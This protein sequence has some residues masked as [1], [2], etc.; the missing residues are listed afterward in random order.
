MFLMLSETAQKTWELLMK[1]VKIAHN[2]I[3]IQLPCY[4]YFYYA[5]A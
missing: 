2:G 5:S 1:N 3:P 4:V